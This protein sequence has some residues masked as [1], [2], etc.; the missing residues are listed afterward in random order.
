MFLKYQKD[1]NKIGTNGRLTT[2]VDVKHQKE[3]E[4]VSNLCA[5]SHSSKTY[6]FFC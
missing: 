2:R 6:I 4:K 5:V 1:E 3:E